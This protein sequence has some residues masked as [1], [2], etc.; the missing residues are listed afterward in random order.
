MLC[1]IFFAENEFYIRLLYTTHSTP[2]SLHAIYS[3]FWNITTIQRVRNSAQMHQTQW[4]EV[5]N[6]KQSMKYWS[7]KSCSCLKEYY[8][9]TIFLSKLHIGVISFGRFNL[10]GTPDLEKRLQKWAEEA[11]NKMWCLFCLEYVQVHLMVGAFNIHAKPLL[12][13]PISFRKGVHNFAKAH[14]L[15]FQARFSWSEP[16]HCS[17]LY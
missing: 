7:S 8:P 4:K 12:L 13:R 2:S 5:Q 9:R 17:D 1:C 11:S 16:H 14:L 6:Q 3:F 15:W 10:Y